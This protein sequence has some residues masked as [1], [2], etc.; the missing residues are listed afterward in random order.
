MGWPI[1]DRYSDVENPVKFTPTPLPGLIEI[2]ATPHVDAR[3]R[4]A[5]AFCIDEFKN[6]GL[7]FVPVQANLSSNENLTL[8]GLHFQPAPYG[9]KKL[10]RAVAG[11]AFDVA[12]DLRDGPTFGKWHAVELCA[13]MMNAI[14]IPEGFAHGFLALEPNTTLLYQMSPAYQGG[15]GAGLRWNDPD[16]A[17]AWP[18]DPQFLSEGDQQ[19][20]YLNEIFLP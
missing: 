4:F 12:V 1:C 14:F 18:A 7:D 19:L 11:R 5:R 6:A 17:I 13:D 2:E 16:I 8:R 20:P 15:R 3:G 10:V 9:E